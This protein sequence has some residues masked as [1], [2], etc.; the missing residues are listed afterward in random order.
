MTRDQATRTQ[1]NLSERGIPFVHM[2]AT[3]GQR[4]TAELE[5]LRALPS[6]VTPPRR[7]SLFLAATQFLSCEHV[8]YLFIQD[9]AHFRPALLEEAKLI[10]GT[11]ASSDR[12]PVTY[13]V[14]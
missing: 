12:Q 1:V 5:F 7:H 4:V 2:A 8:G 6:G 3:H 14:E 9:S 13:Y 11:P 10:A